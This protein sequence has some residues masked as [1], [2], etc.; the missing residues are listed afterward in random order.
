MQ[1][2]LSQYKVLKH[3]R[4]WVLFRV[5]K[6]VIVSVRRYLGLI[7]KIITEEERRSS[8]VLELV[9]LLSQ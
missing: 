1:V 5:L 7:Y 8:Y 3:C 9:T 2:S 6:N 4:F